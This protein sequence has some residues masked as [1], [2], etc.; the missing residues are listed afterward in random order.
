MK[1]LEGILCACVTPLLEDEAID[2]TAA[3]QMARHISQGVN[4]VVALGST[5]EQIALTRKAKR[6]FLEVM[7][8]TLPQGMPLLAGCGST[9]TRLTLEN[10]RDAERAGADAVIV[11]PPCFY[12]FDEDAVVRFYTEVADASHLPM[13]LYNISRC[14]G[15][16]ISERAVERLLA[17][18]NIR[19]IK[20]SDRNEALVQKLVQIAKNRPDFSVLQG[21]DRIFL[22]SFQWGCSAGVTV[23]G[24]LA[25]ELAPALYAAFR[26]GDLAR[27]EA[28]QR[29]LLDF[30]AVITMLGRFPLELKCLMQRKGLCGDKMT[31]PFVPLTQVEK[32]T[33]FSAYE[34]LQQKYGFSE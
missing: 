22:K 34:A 16:A 19:G 29:E 12:S 9:S 4:G 14:V 1:L 13:Y 25:P 11:T 33:L 26:R 21:S 18:P 28:L 30:V 31:S 17:H 3:K 27:A 5:G 20:E 8:E 10:C 23:V 32:E 6:D 7:R 2:R 15:Y 24:N